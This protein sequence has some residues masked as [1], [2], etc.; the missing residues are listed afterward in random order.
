MKSLRVV[1]VMKRTERQP[2]ALMVTGGQEERG[3]TFYIYI[4]DECAGDMCPD[5]VWGQAST[6][7]ERDWSH[8]IPGGL[9]DVGRRC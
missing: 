1:T 5:R 7:S 9:R 4:R 3:E 2:G 6:L 8:L